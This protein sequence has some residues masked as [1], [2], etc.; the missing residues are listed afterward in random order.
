MLDFNKSVGKPIFHSNNIE[1][2]ESDQ[3]LHQKPKDKIDK[4]YLKT[5]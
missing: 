3:F 1:Y 5:A 4:M 2:F